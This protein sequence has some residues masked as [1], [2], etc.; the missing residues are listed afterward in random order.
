MRLESKER[1]RLALERARRCLEDGEYDAAVYHIEQSIID[2]E[3]ETGHNAM[4]ELCARLRE[5]FESSG[6]PLCPDPECDYAAYENTEHAPDCAYMA[7]VKA[8]DA[9]IDTARK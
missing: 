6:H 1:A 4:A 3:K 5:H 9:A 8:Q 7:Y 2:A